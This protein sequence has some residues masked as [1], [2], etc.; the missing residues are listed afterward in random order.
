MFLD[1]SNKVSDDRKTCD[2]NRTQHVLE[3]TSNNG[4]DIAI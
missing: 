4:I 1:I 2:V 3:D